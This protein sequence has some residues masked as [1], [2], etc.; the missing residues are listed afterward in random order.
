VLRAIGAAPG[1][2]WLL[3]LAEA[4]VIVVMSWALSVLGAWPVSRLLGQGLLAAMFRAQLD[5]LFEPQGPVIWLAVCLLLALLASALPAWRASRQ[6]V[7]EAL[8]HE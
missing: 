7:R 4:G 1:V 5:F 6:S 2:I 3:V 8:A